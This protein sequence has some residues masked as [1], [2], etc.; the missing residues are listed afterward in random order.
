V[1]KFYMEVFTRQGKYK[2][3]KEKVYAV[4]F[5]DYVLEACSFSMF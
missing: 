3:A 1:G 5:M 4:V 2:S